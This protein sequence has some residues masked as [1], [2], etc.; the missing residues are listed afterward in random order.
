[1]ESLNLDI[2]VSIV[3]GSVVG[4]HDSDCKIDSV[5]IHS[6]RLGANAAFFALNGN[7]TD[8]HRFVQI[9]LESGAIAVVVNSGYRVPDTVDPS[10]VIFVDDTLQA[11]QRLSSWWRGRLQATVI[12][13]VGGNGK[14]TTKDAVV[15]FASTAGVLYGSPGSY[16]SQ[17]GV[18]LAILQCPMDC[19]I[20][21][22]EAAGSRPGEMEVL[23]SILRPHHVIITNLGSRWAANFRDRHQRARSLLS[24]FRELSSNAWVLIGDLDPALKVAAQDVSARTL[25]L[26]QSDL[27]PRF[28]TV[29][30]DAQ[31]IV[32][33]IEFPDG[34][35]CDGIRLLTPSV[36]I[37]TDAQ[38]A[39]AAAWLLGVA[40][41]DLVDAL[42]S[43]RPTATRTEIWRS[44]RGVT[45]VRDVATADP[46]ALVSAIRAAKIVAGGSHRVSVVLSEPD[47]YWRDGAEDE[48][49]QLLLDEGVRTIDALSHTRYLR[50]RSRLE[51]HPEVFVNLHFDIAS[52]RDQLLEQTTAGDVVLVQSPRDRELPDLSVT[53]MESMAPTRLYIDLSAVEENLSRFR[54]LVGSS[55]KILAMV[56]ALAYGTDA[57]ALSTTLQE[58]GVDMLGV[59]NADE[60]VALRRH[61]IHLPILVMLPLATDMEKMARHGL[62]P[63]VYSRQLLDEIIRTGD[64]HSQIT[65]HLEV[66]TGMHRTGLMPEDA[67]KTLSDLKQLPGIHVGGLMTHFSSADDAAQDESTLAQLRRFDEVVATAARLG[68]RGLIRHAAATAATLR[69]PETHFDMVRIGIGL[70]GVPPSDAAVS[71]FPLLPALSLRSRIIEI[72]NIAEGETV[73]YGRTFRAPSTGKRVGV[74]PAGYHDCVPRAF[75]NHGYVIV[76]GERCGIAGTVSMDSMSV[77]ISQSASVRVGAEVLIY[78]K[79]DEHS[80][81]IEEVAS[82]IGTISYELMA[83]VGSRVQ[84][85][86]TRH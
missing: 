30:R 69:F 49:A 19:N 80:V 32:Y 79:Y 73:G 55:V 12:A 74:V 36:D 75:S 5:S 47:E 85:I 28:E 31:S 20:A 9:A 27:L 68:Y 42:S 43:Y 21:I 22:I 50:L 23:A 1:M 77:D 57:T 39:I 37:A 40:A 38:L 60:G 67:V 61:G 11:L 7:R 63:V 4:G 64:N 70:Y 8:G 81:P 82:A 10:R 72:V 76:D 45:L 65:I 16:N 78:G 46:I 13:V 62:T 3:A 84:R 15:H 59:S 48:I 56:K 44:P 34:I 51:G 41:Y 29:G 33:Q 14:T 17:L 18:A 26:G 86:F 71:A 2:F 58:A 6:S 83:R 54:K 52:L 35:L 66:D 25:A 53:L 24:V